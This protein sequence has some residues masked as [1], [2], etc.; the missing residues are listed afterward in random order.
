MSESVRELTLEEVEL[1]SGAGSLPPIE[2]VKFKLK[3]VVGPWG[4]IY[5]YG[6]TGTELVPWDSVK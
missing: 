5:G 1:V 6:E 3:Y 4:D 2:P